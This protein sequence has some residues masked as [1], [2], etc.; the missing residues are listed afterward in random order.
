[1]NDGSA[2]SDNITTNGSTTLSSAGTSFISDGIKSGDII[3]TAGGESLRVLSVDSTSQ[4]TLTAA[5][6][7]SESGVAGT[8][9]KPPTDG[10]AA[11]PSSEVYGMTPAEVSAGGDNVVSVAVATAGTGY[12]GSAPSVSFSGGGG[13]SAAASATISSGGLTAVTVSNVGSSYTSAPTVTIAP[14]A[15][16]TFNGAS[17]V[18]D[19]AETIT[20]TGHTFNTGDQAAYA[21][22]GGT[23]I[24]IAEHTDGEGTVTAAGNLPATI[25]IIKVDANTIKVAPTELAAINNLPF[26]LT[27]GVGASHT[28]TGVTATATASLGAG[29]DTGFHAGWVKRTVGTGG[30]AG[31]VQY[32][33]LVAASSISGD[34]EDIATPDS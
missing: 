22:G 26:A 34:F 20:L 5:A 3:V 23:D 6:S 11:L 13:S 7:G 19:S 4:I 8:L 32:E 27:D 25:F 31:R 21:D 30:R 16:Y 28:I 2:L 17:G 9:R 24:T 29:T 12:K 14:P 15:A 18:D 1:M 33:T 10:N